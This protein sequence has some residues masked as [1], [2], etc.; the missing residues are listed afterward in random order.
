MFR[1]QKKVND[2]Q[3]GGD[4]LLIRDKNFFN[5]LRLLAAVGV[6]ITHSYALLGLPERDLLTRAT[7]GLLSFSRLG[8]YVFFVISGF[9]VANSLW[10]S[11][12]LKNFFWKRFLRIFPALFVVL[13]LTTFFIGPILSDKNVVEYFYTP[14]T[15]HYLVGGLSL[16]DTQYFLP[17]VFAR[18]LIYGVNGSLWTLPYEWTCYV[19]LVFLLFPFKKRKI[20]GAVILSLVFITIRFLV[21]RYQVFQVIDF[22]KLD[23]RQ[24]M[25]FGALFFFGALGLELKK[26]LKF[27]SII[28][29]PLITFLVWFSFVDKS[30][31]FYF[32]IIILPYLI[33]SLANINLSNKVA[34]FFSRFDYSYGLYIYAFLVGQI[35]VH[36]FQSYLTVLYLA[37]LTLFLTLPFA[38]FSWYFIEKPCLRFKTL[39]NT[40]ATID[41][42][43]KI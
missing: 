30:M 3:D 7:N 13:F 12:S 35:L 8:V 32:Y 25:S 31:A 9:L 15:Y 27:R 39:A 20:W 37:I 11:S 42:D 1:L 33:L 21:G 40:A 2:M 43:K 16:Y 5:L 41:K 6:I 18:N 23:T 28:F 22:L 29:F 19:L 26:Y 10:N 24:L 17:G 34:S 14:G 38:I 4:T 36:Y